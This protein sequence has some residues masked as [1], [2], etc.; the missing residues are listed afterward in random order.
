MILEAIIDQKGLVTDLRVIKSLSKELD[1]EALRA[2]RQWRFRPGTQNG[3]PVPVI[4]SLT[5]NFR[6]Q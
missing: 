3:T 4:F 1:D 6:I 5:V 2:V